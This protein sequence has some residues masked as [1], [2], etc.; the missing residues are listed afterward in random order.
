MAFE[1]NGMDGG[2]PIVHLTIERGGGDGR[3]V[4]SRLNA[5]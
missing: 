2:Q 1:Y 5:G 3:S 4:K